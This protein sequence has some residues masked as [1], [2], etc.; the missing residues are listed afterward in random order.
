MQNELGVEKG[1]EQ[2]VFA[3]EP[4]DLS[5]GDR[6]RLVQVRWRD[7]EAPR[8]GAENKRRTLCGPGGPCHRAPP[9]PGPGN[10]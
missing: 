3:S 4:I 1:R 5:K 6:E 7:T 9:P 2:L 10:V 8:W